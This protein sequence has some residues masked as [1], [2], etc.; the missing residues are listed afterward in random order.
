MTVVILDRPRH[1]QLIEEV[2]EAGARIKLISDGDVA[3]AVATAFPESGVDVMMGI[4]GAP[5]GVLAAAALK[6]LG[7]E[8]Q[9]RL[10]TKNRGR[11]CP[12]A[13]NGLV[14]ILINF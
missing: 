4:G 5:E 6:A 2:R 13:K 1:E 9:G 11:S 14:L 3:P 12:G 8:I 7:G 10:G